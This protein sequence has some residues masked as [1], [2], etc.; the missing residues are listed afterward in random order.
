MSCGG[1]ITPGMPSCGCG[2]SGG[3]CSCGSEQGRTANSKV[4]W[5]PPGYS[6]AGAGVPTQSGTVGGGYAPGAG[7]TA[8]AGMPTLT[9]GYSP[10][11]AG[12]PVYGGP[13]GGGYVPGMGQAV[14]AQQ[15]VL[16]HLPQFIPPGMLSTLSGWQTTGRGRGA[17]GSEPRTG[18]TVTGKECAKII[19]LAVYIVQGSDDSGRGAKLLQRAKKLLASM[20]PWPCCPPWASQCL[21]TLALDIVGQP[22]T[23]GKNAAAVA[24]RFYNNKTEQAQNMRPASGEAR[25]RVPHD[26]FGLWRSS[27]TIE[28]PSITQDAL[29][30]EADWG[31]SSVF[32]SPVLSPG[33]LEFGATGWEVGSDGSNG[34]V[35][36]YDI[37]AVIIHEILHAMGAVHD[38]TSV[39]PN[40]MSEVWQTGKLG[41]FTITANTACEIASK[42]AVCGAK[43][44][45]SC[46]R[47]AA[48]GASNAGR[49]G[50][51]PMT[52]GFMVPGMS[53][54]AAL[55]PSDSAHAG[56]TTHYPFPLKSTGY[57]RF[58]IGVGNP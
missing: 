45:K 15:P 36:A 57:G 7:H 52:D 56:G 6:S 2:G 13:A 30:F 39:I 9:P 17:G 19:T 37:L 8:P 14:S 50:S 42:N 28:I 22:A 54:A 5:T 38:E 29:D 12:D 21:V 3:S 24:A 26:A 55:H 33:A 23:T 25:Q 20:S 16:L 11:G 32:Q 53:V 18:I 44:R 31:S 4:R 40:I 43:E 41:A 47:K 10:A 46:C 27:G 51:V 35:F 49:T 48:H 58:N 1:F 34:L